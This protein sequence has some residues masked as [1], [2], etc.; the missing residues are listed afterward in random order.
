MLTTTNYLI[1]YPDPAGYDIVSAL[2]LQLIAETASAVLAG[3][4][5]LTPGLLRRP[6]LVRART[7]NSTAWAAND[8]FVPGFQTT[9]YDN[10]GGALFDS[11]GA[12]QV[13]ETKIN[14]ECW[15]LIG[16]Q[17]FLSASGTADVNSYREVRMRV[18]NWRNAVGS[19]N[20]IKD[21]AGQSHETNSGGEAVNVVAV[22]RLSRGWA[23]SGGFIHGNTS[24]TVFAQADSKAF[25]TYLAPVT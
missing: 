20:I 9:V 16:A 4:D 6:T 3:F 21:F 19:P 23:A 22:T 2:D 7:G 12:L 8:F 10:T 5:G 24:S 13:D 17:M 14:P 11:G 18:T 1:P 15:V 25:M